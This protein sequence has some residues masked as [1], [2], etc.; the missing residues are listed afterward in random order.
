MLLV[1]YPCA[2]KLKKALIKTLAKIPHITVQRAQNLIAD[3]KKSVASAT[4]PATPQLTIATTQQIINLK[5][6]I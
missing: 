6:Q 2:D 5:K 4:D 1:K 3:A